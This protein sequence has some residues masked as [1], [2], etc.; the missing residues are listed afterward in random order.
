MKSLFTLFLSSLIFF[1][2]EDSEI[3]TESEVPDVRYGTSFGHCIG[4]C[5]TDLEV[6][7]DRL[8][9]VN[10]GWENSEVPKAKTSAFQEEAY[11]QLLSLVNE[12]EFLALEPVIGCPDC[13]DG[14]AE[15]IEMKI[16][17]RTKKV[18]FEYGSDIEEIAEIVKEL[19][20]LTEALS[21]D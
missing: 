19:R 17:N 2:C 5:L 4:Y 8:Y 13:A 10:Y 1:S 15:W 16:G 9:Y 18:T 14:G 11:G 20:I 21:K 7:A 6:S 12:E 3:L